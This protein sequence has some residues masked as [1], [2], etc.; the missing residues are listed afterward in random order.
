MKNAFHFVVIPLAGE[1]EK[2]EDQEEEGTEEE[3]EQ[4]GGSPASVRSSVFQ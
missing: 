1:A 3:E 2:D 4:G